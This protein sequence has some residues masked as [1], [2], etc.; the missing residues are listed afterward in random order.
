L[1][2]YSLK[3]AALGSNVNQNFKTFPSGIKNTIDDFPKSDVQTTEKSQMP[4]A[5]SDP[6]WG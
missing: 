5:V 6:A 2:Q 1:K 4:V 3:V